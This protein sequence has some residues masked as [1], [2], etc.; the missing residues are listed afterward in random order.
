[1]D[2]IKT[3][4]ETTSQKRSDQRLLIIIYLLEAEESTSIFF[5]LH[6]NLCFYW[7]KINGEK[8]GARNGPA[9]LKNGL[10]G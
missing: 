7:N 9:F 6:P 4:V 5:R 8:G 2:S 1:M 3:T 10:I